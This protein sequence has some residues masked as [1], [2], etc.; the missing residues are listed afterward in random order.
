M[1]ANS[2]FQGGDSGGG[3]TELQATL[4]EREA[5]ILQLKEELKAARANQDNVVKQVSLKVK[6]H[7]KEHSVRK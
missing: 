4:H 3:V 2:L 1:S 5:Q 7:P 6:Q